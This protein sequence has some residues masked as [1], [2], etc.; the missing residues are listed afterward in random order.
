MDGVVFII[1]AKY[2]K[3]GPTEG[4]EG[5]RGMKGWKMFLINNLPCISALFLLQALNKAVW[6][7]NERGE[8]NTTRGG[9]ENPF[10][11]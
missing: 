8:V 11:Y 10:F 1:P 5:L 2:Q 3:A 4:K 9:K 7:F 6:W